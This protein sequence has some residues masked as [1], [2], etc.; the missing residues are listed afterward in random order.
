MA[1]SS[2]CTSGA[3]SRASLSSMHLLI[4]T[5]NPGKIKEFREMLAH[6]GAAFSDL[7]AHPDTPA[8]EETGHTFRANACLKAAYYATLFKTHTVADDSGL[9]VDALS[10]SP[11]VHSAR[12]A[13]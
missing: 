2:G 4:D 10:G 12:W 3:S 8:P 5:T 11:G 9:E 13:E 6:T 7:S 1:F